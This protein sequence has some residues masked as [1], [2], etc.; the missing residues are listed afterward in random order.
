MILLLSSLS[1]AETYTIDASHSYV[2]FKVSHM[3]VS[4]VRGEF[5]EVAGTLEYDPADLAATT[6]SATVGVISIDT[7]DEKRDEHLRGA[8]FFDASQFPEATFASTKIDN[9]AED[10]SFDVVGDLTIH[11][12]TKETTF[13]FSPVSDE[14]TDPWGNRKR[15][16]SALA[17][18]N[19]QDFGVSWNKSLDQGGLAVGDEVILEIELEL[20]AAKAE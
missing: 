9:I 10:G 13:R 19:R 2:G 12:V 6:V 20:N 4:T 3:T 8:E 5:G 15:G 14:I 1:F 7:R 11:G 16:G 18:I 17:T